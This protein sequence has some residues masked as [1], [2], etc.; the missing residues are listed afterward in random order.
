MSMEKIALWPSHSQK[1]ENSMKETCIMLTRGMCHLNIS[2]DSTV[3]FVWRFPNAQSPANGKKKIKEN[4]ITVNRKEGWA[5]EERPEGGP[6]SRLATHQGP[7]GL[8]G[9]RPPETGWR[10]LGWLGCFPQGLSLSP[11]WSSPH[12][13]HPVFPP[14]NSYKKTMQNLWPVV[15]FDLAKCHN[16][17]ELKPQ[18]QEEGKH[19]LHMEC[20]ARMTIWIQLDSCRIARGIPFC[21][22]SSES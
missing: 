11:I 20:C 14:R 15:A 9:H 5:R 12:T 19:V 17:D 22:R 6:A 10:T 7:R 18:A 2:S 21:L 4:E 1:V 13:L 16:L 3:L 8:W